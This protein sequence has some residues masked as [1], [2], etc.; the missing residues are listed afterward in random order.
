MTH[1]RS[2]AP[3]LAAPRYEARDASVTRLLQLGLLLCVVIALTL[4]GVARLMTLLTERQPAGQPASTLGSTP[5][6]PPKPR[7]QTTPRLDLA[8]RR[9][10]EDATLNSY[11]W[12]DRSAGSIRIPINRAM[13]LLVERAQKER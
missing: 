5:D 12:I 7:L 10:A 11:A 2:G 4:L 3:D 8:A 13:D 6:L 1:E 9:R